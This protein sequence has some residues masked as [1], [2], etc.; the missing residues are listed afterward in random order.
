METEPVLKMVF[1]SRNMQLI[2]LEKF[3]ASFHFV[4][5]GRFGTQCIFLWYTS[6]TCEVSSKLVWAPAAWY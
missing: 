3:G 1:C 2:N 6:V 4:G 5:A